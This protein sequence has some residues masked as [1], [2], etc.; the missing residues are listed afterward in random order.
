MFC[1]VCGKETDEELRRGE[2]ASCYLEKN[3]LASVKENVD[4]EVCVHCHARRR[5]E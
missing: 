4:V 2:C 5:G 1:V 3:V